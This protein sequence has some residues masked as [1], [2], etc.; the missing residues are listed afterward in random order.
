MLVLLVQ[1]SW[2]ELVSHCATGWISSK[3][4]IGE[5]SNSLEGKADPTF[6]LANLGLWA[7]LMEV[8]VLLARCGFEAL[9][10]IKASID[11]PK[12]RS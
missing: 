9:P 7:V 1:P 8:R 5:V 11:G 6:E 12:P 2:L 4:Y 3:A 10:A